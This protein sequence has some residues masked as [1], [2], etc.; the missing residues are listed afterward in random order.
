[1]G[2]KTVKPRGHMFY[3]GLYRQTHQQLLSETTRPRALVFGMK[4]H[5]MNLCQACA[6]YIPGAKNGPHRGHMFN[7][8]LYRENMKNLLV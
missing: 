1:M 5:I 2:L 3:I 7:R 4:H 8:G 6:N